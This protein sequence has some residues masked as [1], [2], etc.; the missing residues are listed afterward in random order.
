MATK[1]Q[2]AERAE[3]IDRLRQWI[4]PGDTVYTVLDHVSSSGMSRAIRVLVP[5][6]NGRE[7]ESAAPGGKPTDYIRKDSV[8]V[9]FLHPNWA[10]GK[11]LGLRH[12]RKHGREQD[13]LVM[14]GC[15]MDMGFAL[16]YELSQTLYGGRLRQIAEGEVL[17][18][19][20]LG[21]RDAPAGY[22]YEGG[23]VCLGKGACPSNYHVNHRDHVRCDGGLRSDGESVHCYAPFAFSRYPVAEDHPR[24]MVDIGEGEQVEGGYLAVLS[25]TGEDGKPYEVCPTCAGAGSL[26]NPEGP[27]R[28]DLVHTDGYALRHRWL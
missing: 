28:W 5:T 25:G 19:G 18:L 14:G 12:W 23:Y 15:G 16:V 11:A 17:P 9:D 24:R 2:Q 13:A 22:V 26:P 20:T 10:V 3:A 6:I 7:V 4:K 27:E 21:L 8:H 1:A